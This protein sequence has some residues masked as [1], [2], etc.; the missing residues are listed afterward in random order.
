M[1][2]SM[3]SY[4]A[5]GSKGSTRLHM[6]MAD[7]LNIMTYAASCADGSPGYAAWDLFRA[8]DSEQIRA[9]LREKFS[10]A[11]PN[12]ANASSGSNANGGAGSAS[13]NANGQKGK[14]GTGRTNEWSGINDPIHGQQFYLDEQLR[15][16]L[17]QRAGVMSFRVYQRPGEAVFIPAGC[18][19][20]VRPCAF[21]PNSM[22]SRSDGMLLC[23]CSRWQICRIASRWQ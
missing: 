14:T 21:F 7:A 18:A 23:H 10:P 8:Q 20:Q 11:L 15:E 5:A 16:E 13:A 22:W 17:F 6:D 2:N 1:Y 9:F 12:G 3:A 4:Q 19:H